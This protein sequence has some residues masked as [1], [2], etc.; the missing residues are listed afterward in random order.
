MR[1]PF[2]ASGLWV[3]ALVVSPLAFAQSEQDWNLEGGTV[4]KSKTLSVGRFF[5]M[6]INGQS[7]P[8]RT[9][10]DAV[11]KAAKSGG[12]ADSEAPADGRQSQ[13]GFEVRPFKVDRLVRRDDKRNALLVIDTIS[14]TQ[15]QENNLQLDYSTP[16][17]S[18]G[19]V[20]F[21]GTLS[22]S[23][24]MRD[25]GNGM[26]DGTWSAIVMAEKQGTPAVP[27][28]IWGQ[29]DAPWRA[30]LQDSGSTLRLR[31]E[32]VVPANGKVAFLHWV[33][34]AGLDPKVKLERTFDLFIKDG[35]LLEPGVSAEVAALVVNFK[36]TSLG[37]TTTEGGA[38]TFPRAGRLLALDALTG[39]L[40]IKRTD[41]GLLWMSKDE[42]IPGDISVVKV[43]LNLASG[44]KEVPP[45]NIAALRGGAGRGRDHRLYLRDG[46]VLTG[47]VRLIKGALKGDLGE[48]ALDADAMEL[49]TWPVSTEDGRV[50]ESAAEF[51][52]YMD[53]SV[54]WLAKGA[55]VAMDLV[56]SFGKLKIS[57]EELWTLGRRT[58]PPYCMVATLTDGSRIQGVVGGGAIRREVVGDGPSDIALPQVVRWGAVEAALKEMAG[59][60]EPK[61][62][63]KPTTG[64]ALNQYCWMR[65]GSLL[66]GILQEDETLRVRTSTGVLTLKPDAVARVFWDFGTG[67]EA[68]LELGNGTKVRGE[69]LNEN[70]TW[71]LDKQTVSLPVGLITEIVRK[72]KS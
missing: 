12:N 72:A 16:V 6:G 14:N 67:G 64:D 9:A 39:K 46:T 55:P 53:G 69:I 70:L 2:S 22:Q 26:P 71:K 40:D 33:G 50:P 34:T 8:Y 31:Y 30:V 60:P 57:S 4:W 62:S 5:Q 51:V 35:K 48:L 59:G 63:A 7:T 25:L 23:G 10:M 13:M 61:E 24:E 45:A 41:K 43:V 36:P 3:W 54:R 58:D 42:Q 52:Q 38:P 1:I 21:S 11:E 32:G 65:D 27:L 17:G 29:P 47:R 19:G 56:A 49:L 18:Q 15:G 37:A 44:E 66:V 28:F 68:A 20:R